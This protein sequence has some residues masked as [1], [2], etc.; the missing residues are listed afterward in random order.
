MFDKLE[1]VEFRFLEIESKLSDP[2]L[3][4]R[5]EEFRRLSKEHSSLQEIVDEYRIYRRL[6]SEF[7]SSKEMLD[8]GDA[9]FSSMAKE[10]MK[11]LEPQLHQSQ[12][13][14]QLLLLPQDPNDQKNVLIEIRAGAGGEEAALFAAELWRLYQRFSERQGWKCDLMSASQAEKG[15]LKEVIM[16]VEGTKVYSRLKFEAG[17]HRVQRVPETEAQGRVHT[18][19][20]TVAILPEA[21]DVDIHINP[22][23]LRIDVF[24]S[25]G[26]GGQSVNTTDS[27]VRITHIP[28][29]VVV[30]CQDERSQLK[31]KDKAMKILRSRI[32]EAE[33]EKA[34][35]SESDARR[36]MVG[37]GDRSERIRTYNFPQ[38]RLTD[39]RIGFTLYQL[40]EV[41]EGK[42]DELLDALQTHYQSESL[43]QAGYAST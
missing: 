26:S 43:K 7:V 36:A 23:D 25:S 31:N 21:E 2:S 4:D 13:K 39:H 34:A 30:A 19:T 38:G 35:K 33:Q 9:E 12:A 3:A 42:I 8:S 32:L 5:P 37:T 16:M 15:G 20:V 10:E 40:P 11:L 22:A 29:G 18:S 27:A 28:S 14:L 6:K 1:A 24:R 41:M 17:V